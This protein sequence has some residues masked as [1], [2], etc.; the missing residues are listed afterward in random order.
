M[1][2]LGSSQV[3][4]GVD[5]AGLQLRAP[6]YFI[7]ILTESMELVT[8]VVPAA[9]D[10]PYGSQMSAGCLVGVAC[11]LAGSKGPSC[12]DQ[13]LFVIFPFCTTRLMRIDER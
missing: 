4:L 6:C 7:L 1:N 3:N 13:S 11:I 9:A 12:S 5:S 10:V 2:S 8:G